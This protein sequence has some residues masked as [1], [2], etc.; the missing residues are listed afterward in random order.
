MSTGRVTIGIQ[1]EGEEIVGNSGW[2]MGVYSCI[3]TVYALLPVEQC[4]QH[5]RA[6]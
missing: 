2:E 1:G 3:S 6:T 4:K 5:A